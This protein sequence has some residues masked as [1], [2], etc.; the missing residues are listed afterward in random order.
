MQVGEPLAIN[1]ALTLFAGAY[2][3]L[4]AH[5]EDELFE[6]LSRLVTDTAWCTCLGQH[7]DMDAE[8]AV[9]SA[10]RERYDAIVYYKTT[11]YT[12]Y[13]PMAAGI[14]VAGLDDEAEEAALLA[15][16]KRVSERIGALFQMQD[17]YLDCYGDPQVTGKVGTDVRD[18]KCTWL[19]VHAVETLGEAER[20][21]LKAL[22][23]TRRRRAR[24]GAGTTPPAC[25]TSTSAASARCATSAS[26]CAT[27]SSS[28]RR[29]TSSSAAARSPQRAT[30]RAPAL[31]RAL[32][33]NPPAIAL[34][35][36][37]PPRR[38]PPRW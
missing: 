4:A 24:A 12:V 28:S 8:G 31:F 37:P 18:G 11:Y 10:T 26:A 23:G 32:R 17:D 25:A 27:G 36:D 15:N 14:L 3:V 13:Q 33:L 20:G 5:F 1:D 19:F 7:L 34:S 21:D 6:K 29:S 30:R 2:R 16:A 22:Y 9:D 38:S 35:W